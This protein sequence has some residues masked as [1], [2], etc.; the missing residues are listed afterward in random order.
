MDIPQ[1]DAFVSL[2]RQAD[3]RASD[4][5]ASNLRP[6]PRVMAA[7]GGFPLMEDRAIIGGIGISGGSWAQ[8]QEAGEE[9]LRNFAK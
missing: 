9:A 4:H 6:V 2:A 7:A 3:H 8:D 5:G 1:S